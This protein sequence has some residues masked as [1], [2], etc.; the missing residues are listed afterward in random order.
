MLG[1]W[2]IKI[3]VHIVHSVKVAPVS[4]NAH[5]FDLGCVFFAK[6]EM[7]SDRVLA[8]P[9]LLRHGFIHDCNAKG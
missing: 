1:E 2:K 6:R 8:G 4:G 5:D 7:M 3:S 9:Q